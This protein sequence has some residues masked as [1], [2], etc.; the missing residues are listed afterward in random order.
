MLL[1]TRAR[2]SRASAAEKP[3]AT[4]PYYTTRHP[5]T[6]PVVVSVHLPCKHRTKGQG[7]RLRKR[8]RGHDRI[9]G[10]CELAKHQRFCS[11][12]KCTSERAMF[13]IVLCRAKRSLI[14]QM[15]VFI[16]HVPFK[17]EQRAE[18]GEN[19]GKINR[20]LAS[21]ILHKAHIH[22]HRYADIYRCFTCAMLSSM[23]SLST[24]DHTQRFILFSNVINS[25]V[26]IADRVTG[27]YTLS[28]FI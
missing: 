17:R 3:G 6:F 4:T 10:L 7:D 19:F 21:L 20:S 22:A 11:G 28:I 5:F 14:R 27:T 2:R 8:K 24:R 12:T 1:A 23:C 9:I 26:P 25:T 13:H 18:S 15:M 16:R